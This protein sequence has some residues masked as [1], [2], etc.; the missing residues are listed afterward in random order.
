MPQ[1]QKIV[2]PIPEVVEELITF[3]LYDVVSEKIFK[4]DGNFSI[5]LTD[6]YGVYFK[7]SMINNRGEIYLS[8]I[9]SGVYSVS[10]L[11]DGIKDNLW[12]D[13]KIAITGNQNE[14]DF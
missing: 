2:V 13:T 10:V 9:P 6:Q 5:L 14:F 12:I 7:E 4:N 3:R 1:N 8:S 11:R